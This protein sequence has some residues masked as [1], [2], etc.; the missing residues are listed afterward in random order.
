MEGGFQVNAAGER[1]SNEAAGYSEQ[2]VNVVAQ[3]GQFA[4]DIYDERLHRLMLEFDDYRDAVEA[5]AIVQSPD[6]AG[7]AQLTGLPLRH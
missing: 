4:W 6:L 5:R 1:F 7:L 2:A 3:P